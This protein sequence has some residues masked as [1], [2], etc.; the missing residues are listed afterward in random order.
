MNDELKTICLDESR[1]RGIC[2]ASSNEAGDHGWRGVPS[3][4]DDDPQG[5]IRRAHE[6]HV[7]ACPRAVVG[8]GDGREYLAHTAQSSVP[9]AG[10]P[11][12]RQ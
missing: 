6:D 8:A 5:L 11:A 12:E 4:T 10:V 1:Q 2:A 9:R 7:N 3:V